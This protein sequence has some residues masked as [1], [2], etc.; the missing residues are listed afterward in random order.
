MR[1]EES[2]VIPH[3]P[4]RSCAWA[5]LSAVLVLAACSEGPPSPRK[6]QT[7]KLMAEAAPPPPPKPEEKKPE[8]PK[9]EKQE[10]A[11]PKQEAEPASALK[12][13]EAAGDGPGNGLVA[14]SVTQDYSGEKPAEKALIGSAG[15]D[16]TA[17]LAA[18]SFANATARNL[19]D[20]LARERELKR[21]EFRAQIHLWLSATGALE[22]VEL[23]G[24]TGDVGT[25][26][27]LRE[28]LLRFPGST[29][30]PP[31]PL[32]QPLR[33]QVTNRMLG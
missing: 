1:L 6:M 15:G 14:G 16:A 24:S 10:A 5:L 28:A 25:D 7:V 33:I 19:N 31:Q 9:P 27:A 23:V 17:R 2:S 21:A 4:R 8:P 22:R 11:A 20:F 30:P 29:A 3:V 12:S 18:T 26:R 32:P 13:D